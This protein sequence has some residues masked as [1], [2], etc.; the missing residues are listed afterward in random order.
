MVYKMVGGGYRGVY[1]GGTGGCMGRVL[2]WTSPTPT[3]PGRLAQPYP[4][5]LPGNL[6]RLDLANPKLIAGR[7]YIPVF[8]LL[9]IG[10][11]AHV[12]QTLPNAC[13]KKHVGHMFLVVFC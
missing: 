6:T 11:P 5:T 13:T 7:T 8:D 4:A 3:G 1:G 9:W 10:G 12:K 2:G